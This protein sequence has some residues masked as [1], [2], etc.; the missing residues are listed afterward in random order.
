MAN[1]SDKQ[2]GEFLRH[3]TIDTVERDRDVQATITSIPSWATTG[4]VVC[5]LLNGDVIWV[6][7]SGNLQEIAVS[8]VIWVRKFGVGQRSQYRMTGFWKDSGGTYKAPAVRQDVM[9]N[10]K[11]SELWASDGDPQAIDVDASGNTTIN[12]AGGDQDTIIESANEDKILV[13]DAGL[14]LARVGD[15]D[16]NYWETDNAGDSKWVGGGGLPFGFCYGNEIAWAQASAV[17][18][19]WY[20]ISDADMISGPL[21]NVTH[22]GSG[23]LAVAI[24]GMYAAD[25]AGSFEAGS[26]NV[27]VQVTFSIDGTEVNLGLN[28]F[29]TVGASRQDPC[30]GHAILDLAATNTVNVSIRTTDA[31]TPN[32]AIDHLMLR[33]FHIGGT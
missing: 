32:L 1:L 13:V 2:V 21:H 25:W 27:H 11:P 18:N 20:D 15:F 22:D 10:S 28:H 30:A 26:A 33:L 19:Q 7:A 5:T 9:T 24:A 4:E 29:E 6:S 23:Q 31:G 3:Q 17:Q 14:D 8:D 12:P 16:T